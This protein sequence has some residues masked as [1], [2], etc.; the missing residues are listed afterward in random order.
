MQ[1]QTL[2][3]LGAADLCCTTI[4]H[5]TWRILRIWSHTTQAIGNRGNAFVSLTNP[6]PFT[7]LLPK[8]LRSTRISFILHVVDF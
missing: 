4:F 6:S 2:Q 3:Q 5:N 1:S 7:T 8:A